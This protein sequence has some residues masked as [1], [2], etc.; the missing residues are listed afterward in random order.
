MI[1]VAADAAAGRD[2]VTDLAL[3]GRFEDLAGGKPVGYAEGVVKKPIV[4]GVASEEGRG[5]CLRVHS[6]DPEAVGSWIT[7]KAIRIAP[8][9]EAR[10]LVDVRLDGVDPVHGGAGA[11][12]AF[13]FYRDGRY[14]SYTSGRGRPGTAGWGVLEHV[15]RVP[16]DANE[17]RVSLRLSQAKGTV[18]FDNLRVLGRAGAAAERAGEQVEA[19][20]AQMRV[21]LLQQRTH[22]DV[23]TIVSHLRHERI[24]VDHFHGDNIGELPPELEGL[25]VYTAI[26]YSSLALE[27]GVAALSTAQQEAIVAYVEA[28]GGLCTVVAEL[29]GSRLA[30][31]LPI[32]CGGV[33][34]GVH[35]IPEVAR[36]NHPI[37]LD[38]PAEWPGFGSEWNAYNEARLRP[39]AEVLMTIPEAVAPRGTPF[40]SAWA[41][42]RGRVVCVNSLWCF[43]TGAEFKGWR[44]APRFFAQCVRWAGSRPPLAPSEKVAPPAWD[45]VAGGGSAWAA[46]MDV[47]SLPGELRRALQATPRPPTQPVDVVIDPREPYPP[48][49]L[50]P[51]RAPVVTHGGGLLDIRLGNGFRIHFAEC[52]AIAVETADGL[53]LTP[54]PPTAA[55]NPQISESGTEPLQLLKNVDAETMNVQGAAPAS[56]SLCR[57]IRYAAHTIVGDT[58]VVRCRIEVPDGNEARLDWSFRPRTVRIGGREW[59]GF[60]H[61]FRLVAESH[62]VESLADRTPWRIGPTIRGHRT[63]RMACYS[64]PRGFHSLTFQSGESAHTGKWSYFS[65][66]QPF[67][68]VGAAAGTLF[69]YL[70]TPA[71]V[72]GWTETTPERDSLL[73]THQIKVGRQ[74]GTIVT[75]V[76]WRLFSGQQLT[77]N[78]WRQLYDFVNGAYCR[79]AGIRPVAPVPS[80]MCRFD[81]VGQTGYI[82]RNAAIEPFDYRQMAD[83]FLPV[84]AACG[85][86]RVDIGHVI[87]HEISDTAFERNGGAE[88][89]TYLVDKAHRLGMEAYWYLR[90][91]IY[92]ENLR[93]FREHPDW[94]VRTK[95]G[96]PYQGSFAGL[97]VLSMKSGWFDYSL[98]LYRQWRRDYG[99]D[100]VWFDT[101][102]F[103]FDP[104][105]YADEQPASMVPDGIRYLRAF[106]DMGYGYW[107][108]GQS[109]YGLDSFWYRKPKYAGDFPGNEFALAHTSPWTYGPDGAFFLDLFKLASYHCCMVIDVRLML[110]GT[111]ALTRRISRCNQ[112]FNRAVELIGHP[113]LVRQTDFGTLWIAPRGYAL[114]AHQPRKVTVRGAPLPGTLEVLGHGSATAEAHG[115]VKADLWTE[116]VLVMTRGEP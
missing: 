64:S 67:Q 53:A 114:F 14:R 76:E 65:S 96:E 104:F 5:T 4:F 71:T 7:S 109:P 86:K 21:A 18:L 94:I 26:I 61:S 27:G 97:S 13:H 34:K 106:Q 17:V 22:S 15:I 79:E 66:G 58:V 90:I 70:D 107:V 50:P 42:G 2:S 29:P 93:M 57:A 80:A 91:A 12:L 20:P 40:L 37:L 105:N 33:R 68:A 56:H 62:F 115:L 30:Q 88:G 16:A 52:G 101:V 49:D 36:S 74:R 83:A 51:E 81:S 47:A 63:M 110:D 48:H 89:L 43:G 11:V 54:A 35:F 112:V 8:R 72:M 25:R 31:L 116:D 59:R 92:N 28:G 44:Y 103:A 3:N 73:V 78:L 32:E 46:G 24:A 6:D 19:S 10:V 85:V 38:I 69:T 41:L 45:A 82:G 102:G 111:S 75:P 95:D 113:V 98:A 9:S 84:A 39:G 55:G 108:E 60:G 99:M 87:G 77:P 1:A 23:D 100:G